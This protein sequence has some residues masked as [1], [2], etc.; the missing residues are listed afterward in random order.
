MYQKRSN[1]VKRETCRHLRVRSVSVGSAP[2]RSKS[3]AGVS[4]VAAKS[5]A[6]GQY[7]K[8][9]MKACKGRIL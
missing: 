5:Q 3:G 8:R 6:H 7:S 9:Y 4:A 1:G 2:G